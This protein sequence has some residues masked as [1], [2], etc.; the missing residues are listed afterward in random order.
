MFVFI[1]TFYYN[2]EESQYYLQ[3]IAVNYCVASKVDLVLA[4]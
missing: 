4:V 2:Q 3:M 1:S